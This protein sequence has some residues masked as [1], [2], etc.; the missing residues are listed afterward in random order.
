MSSYGYK[1][2]EKFEELRSVLRHSLPSRTMLNNVS[3]GAIE[4]NGMLI[5]LKNRYDV[6]NS[7]D[8][9]FI[10]YNEKHDPNYHYSE[11]KGKDVIFD[12]QLL[13]KA[14]RDALMDFY[15]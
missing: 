1:R 12:I 4:I 5:I 11:L 7:H 3:I 15:Y 9:S 10:H 2:S 14:G 13:N 6:Y 8:I